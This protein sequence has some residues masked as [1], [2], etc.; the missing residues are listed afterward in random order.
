VPR[1]EANGS[2]KKFVS[3]LSSRR[4][5]TNQGLRKEAQ[6][7]TMSIVI[8]AGKFLL[9]TISLRTIYLDHLGSQSTSVT[10]PPNR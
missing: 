6:P 8:L 1:D 2:M 10:K 5:F 4:I 7:M 3:V 9:P